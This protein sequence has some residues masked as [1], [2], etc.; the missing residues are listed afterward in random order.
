VAQSPEGSSRF[1]H[2]SPF[3]GNDPHDRPPPPAPAN[4][5]HR[6]RKNPIL[7]VTRSRFASDSR[8]AIPSHPVLAY[9]I[10]SFVPAFFIVKKKKKRNS[11]R[12]EA[13]GLSEISAGASRA[14]DLPQPPS[15]G[16]PMAR[17]FSGILKYIFTPLGDK[18][19]SPPGRC[20]KPGISAHGTATLYL[21]S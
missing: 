13:E 20:I 16:P 3:H 14:R 12:G 2:W 9:K 8:F 15:R 5:A 17:I 11:L 1:G 6:R 7:A 4:V 18:G 19:F 21:T 10:L